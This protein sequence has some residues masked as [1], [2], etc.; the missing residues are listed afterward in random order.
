[1][2]IGGVV[3]ADG[4]N[5]GYQAL[6]GRWYFSSPRSINIGAMVF[7]GVGVLWVVVGRNAYGHPALPKRPRDAFK[8]IKYLKLSYNNDGDADDEVDTT[9]RKKAEAAI[10][11]ATIFDESHSLREFI[12]FP[13]TRAIPINTN[14]QESIKWLIKVNS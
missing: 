6:V 9:K 13:Y 11:L 14:A 7:D 5:Q 8:A 1:M 12:L 4:G 3:A 10:D 2:F